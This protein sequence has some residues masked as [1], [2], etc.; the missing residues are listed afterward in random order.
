MKTPSITELRHC[1]RKLVRELGMLELNKPHLN[2]TP[3]HWHA[4]I[5]THNHPGITITKLGSLLLL[6]Y[7]TISRIVTSLFN[8]KLILIETGQDKRENLLY[9]TEKGKIEVENIDHY[10]NTK[11]KVAFDFFSGDEQVDIII[12]IQKYAEALKK[13]RVLREQVK[14]STLSTSRAIRKQLISLIENIQKNEFSIPITEETNAG[15]LKAEN[16]YYYNHSCN[17]WYALNH[18]GEIIGSIGLKKI[19]ETNAEIKKFFVHQQYRGKEVA[20]KLMS[21]LIKSALKHRFTTL[22]L[23]TVSVL[24]AAQHFYKKYGFS[25]IDEHDL[26]AKFS[27]CALDNVFFKLNCSKVDNERVT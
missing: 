27:K 18:A 4:L 9:I 7:S 2:R 17:F 3:Q 20:Q 16:E 22:Y 13:S 14:I 15:I 5:E 11:I 21:T 25:Q 19:D 12:A 23:G 10:S 24:L 8:D 26:P 1:S 6:T